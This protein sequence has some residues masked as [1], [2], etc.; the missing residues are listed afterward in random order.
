V[1]TVKTLI[2][3]R[4]TPKNRNC[5]HHRIVMTGVAECPYCLEPSLSELSRRRGWLVGL[6]TGVVVFSWLV[7]L[8][9]RH[10]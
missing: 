10:G 7:W 3:F 6:W 2:K 4:E 5:I 8:T 9:L 1:K